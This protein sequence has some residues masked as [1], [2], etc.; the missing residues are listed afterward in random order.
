MSRVR[1]SE[2]V[3][4]PYSAVLT[5]GLFSKSEVAFIRE[6]YDKLSAKEIATKLHRGVRSVSC[7]IRLMEL[8][9]TW[10]SEE[11]RKQIIRLAE[12]TIYSIRNIAG[13]AEVSVYLV[14]KTLKATHVNRKRR[15]RCLRRSAALLNGFSSTKSNSQKQ[16]EKLLYAARNTCYSCGKVR[17]P[18]DLVTYY[19]F[20]RL[21]VKVYVVC[22][23][24]C[25][26]KRQPKAKANPLNNLDNLDVAC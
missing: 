6:N 9:K 3:S 15:Y 21:P 1:K 26:Q 23:E 14:S 24:G 25:Q 11:Q 10:V 16:K 4:L 13:I 19:D 20:S 8:K 17:A 22:R 12:T 18:E 5:R 7:K 2:L